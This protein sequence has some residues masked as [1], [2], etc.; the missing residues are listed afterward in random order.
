[1]GRRQ[2]EGNQEVDMQCEV[3]MVARQLIIGIW[4][5]GKRSSLNR[6]IL[7]SRM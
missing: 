4:S 3:K 1:M 7:E 6:K 5:S 2:C